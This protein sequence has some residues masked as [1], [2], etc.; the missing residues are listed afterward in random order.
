MNPSMMNSQVFISWISYYS[1]ESFSFENIRGQLM[2][3][4]RL[5]K[6][7]LSWNAVRLN[8]WNYCFFLFMQLLSFQIMG[9]MRLL[10][11]Q[12]IMKKCLEIEPIV[13]AFSSKKIIV[14]MESI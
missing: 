9:Y 3:L 12:K 1:T 2:Q 8:N 6:L 4:L 5:D 10:S 13:N 11:A 7:Y 14:S